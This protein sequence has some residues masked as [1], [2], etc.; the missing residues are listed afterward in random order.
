MQCID[1]Y[2]NMAVP[3]VVMQ[4]QKHDIYGNNLVFFCDYNGCQAYPGVEVYVI[5]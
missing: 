4:V 2:S 3:L 5:N 1:Q